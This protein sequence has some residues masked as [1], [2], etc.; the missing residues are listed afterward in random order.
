MMM[1]PNTKYLLP[2]LMQR[3]KRNFDS[4]II[5]MVLSSLP[6]MLEAKHKSKKSKKQSRIKTL[7]QQPNPLNTPGSNFHSQASKW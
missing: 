1:N 2:K 7:I 4:K 6:L 5:P 3:N